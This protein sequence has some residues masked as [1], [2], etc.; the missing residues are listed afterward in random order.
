MVIRNVTVGAPMRGPPAV[1]TDLVDA[2][3]VKSRDVVHE[4]GASRLGE[5]AGGSRRLELRQPLVC[6]RQ[7]AKPRE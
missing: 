6:L 1:P 2:R 5:D 7:V 4:R 3:A